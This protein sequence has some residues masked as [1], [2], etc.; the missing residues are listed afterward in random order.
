MLVRAH[1]RSVA[2]A[3]RV[4]PDCASFLLISWCMATWP[5]SRQCIVHSVCSQLV[6]TLVMVSCYSA[7][8]PR[9]LWYLTSHSHYLRDGCGN[10][11]AT[12]LFL[13]CINSS[14][15]WW[16]A[17]TLTHHLLIYSSWAYIDHVLAIFNFLPDCCAKRQT[18]W[19]TEYWPTK[20][21][22]VH[23]SDLLHVKW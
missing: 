7:H 16:C 10:G 8:G 3:E 11:P 21:S 19:D 18:H 20:R 15:M 22:N 14:I 17:V 1:C 6:T 5:P 23:I 9:R 13:L 12:H 4:I 2:A